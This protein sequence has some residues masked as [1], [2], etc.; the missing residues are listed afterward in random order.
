MSS[1]K[2]PEIEVRAK[3]EALGGQM[4]RKVGTLLVKFGYGELNE[5]NERDIEARLEAVGIGCAPALKGL[6]KSEFVT[7]YLLERA[8]G[9]KVA[10]PTESA[11]QQLA[12]EAV[13]QT[14]FQAVAT[15]LVAVGAAFTVYGLTRHFVYGL[16]FGMLTLLGLGLV[17]WQLGW[18][19]RLLVPRFPFLRLGWALGGLTMVIVA[20]IG[21]LFVAAPVAAVRDS[22]AREREAQHLL[23]RADEALDE[24]ELASAERLIEEAEGKDSD[25]DG[26]DD[27]KD[28]LAKEEATRAQEVRNRG[29]YEDAEEAMRSNQ[30]RRAIS[31]MEA[32]GDYEDAR[33]RA[34]SFRATAARELMA[35]GRRALRTDTRTALLFARRAH[36]IGPSAKTKAFQTRATSAHAAY[37]AEQRRLALERQRQREYERQQRELERQRQREYERQQREY[38]R[39]QRELERQEEL[40]QY[41]TPDYDTPDTGGSTENWCGATRDGDGDGLWCEE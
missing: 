26:L 3:V 29:D 38:E 4:V 23:D 6:S 35:E 30:Y 19:V 37:K 2:T 12:R 18:L 27:A 16:I 24:G 21:A 17:R 7:L 39:Q 25:A 40:E 5:K 8:G 22:Q 15:G 34:I 14:T 10:P 33:E 13:Q 36:R 41:E 28:R 32:L 1:V 31:G 20:L 9:E 11:T